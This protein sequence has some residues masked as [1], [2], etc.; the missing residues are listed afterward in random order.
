MTIS[1]RSAKPEDAAAIVTLSAGLAEALRAIGNPSHAA[2]DE[3]TLRA[4]GFGTEAVFSVLVAELDGIVAGYLLYHAGFDPDRGGRV[5][6]VVDLYVSESQRRR[7][8]GSA[9]MRAA[10]RASRKSGGHALVWWLREAN[11]EAIAFYERLGAQ[12]S[13]RVRTMHLPLWTGE[14]EGA[15]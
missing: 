5:H 2:L 13:P 8:V 6:Y 3:E 9:L 14:T 12:T 11:R 1:V 10:A 7:G 4:E 15:C